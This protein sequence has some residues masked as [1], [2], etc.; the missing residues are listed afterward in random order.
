MILEYFRT[1]RSVTTSE[2][3]DILRS[4]MKGNV[5]RESGTDKDDLVKTIKEFGL[6]CR[7][8]P[9]VTKDEKLRHLAS[10]LRAGRPA[11]LW[12]RAYFQAHKRYAHY[13]VLT[14]LDERYLYL[15]DPYPDK[16]GRV[17]RSSFI[18]NGQ[19]MSW[20]TDA[21]GIIV[22]PGETRQHA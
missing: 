1:N 17:E 3:E 4:T 19:E 16:P 11:I 12:C 2:W 21:W 18:K 6:T 14:G 13:V 7:K 15:N 10:A 9:G 8:I 20:G 22:G 5:Y